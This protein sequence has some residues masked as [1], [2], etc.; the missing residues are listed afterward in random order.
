MEAV[1]LLA[2]IEHHKALGVE[3]F[4]IYDT[5]IPSS[6]SGSSDSNN[7]SNSSSVNDV[8]KFLDGFLRDGTVTLVPWKYLGCVNEREDPLFCGT[9][10]P[11]LTRD[12]EDPAA[13]PSFIAPGRVHLSAALLSCFLRFQAHSEW[14]IAMGENEFLKTHT[15]SS[16]QSTSHSRSKLY[17]LLSQTVRGLKGL[18]SV[19]IT[20]SSY[21]LCLEK[22]LEL[23]EGGDD[24]NDMM[25]GALSRVKGAWTKTDIPLLSH[26]GSL[27]ALRFD[28]QPSEQRKIVAIR[29]VSSS[30]A[31][32]S[33]PS[34]FTSSSSSSSSPISDTQYYEFV[35]H[36]VRGGRVANNDMPYHDSSEVEEG[37]WRGRGGRRKLESNSS[38][39]TSSRLRRKYRATLHS[40]SVP[41]HRSLLYGMRLREPKRT[42]DL[43]LYKALAD[44]YVSSALADSTNTSSQSPNRSRPL[45][46]CNLPT[47]LKLLSKEV[48]ELVTGSMQFLGSR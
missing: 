30:H 20:L 48:E 25:M 24:D 19:Q 13:Y 38:N 33:D 16:S 5:S 23:E 22:G 46:Y 10:T 2:W 21:H 31:Q 7:S 14:L 17:S 9:E 37:G 26:K 41:I 35:R 27:Q 45:P 28:Q 12:P 15:S 1:H 34:E 29:T 18:V 42:C 6:S 40:N 32:S 8:Y 36:L 11:I 4:F 43:S 39:S 3:H 47:Q 44:F